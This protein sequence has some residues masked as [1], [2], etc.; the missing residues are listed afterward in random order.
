MRF[1]VD[2]VSL[3]KKSP[4]PS[5]G[6]CHE[7][8]LQCCPCKDAKVLKTYLLWGAGGLRRTQAMKTRLKER[9]EN[10]LAAQ[11]AQTAAQSQRM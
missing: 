8:V 7:A 2:L 5:A 10:L 9:Q 6:G 1:M 11:L 4:V 3:Q